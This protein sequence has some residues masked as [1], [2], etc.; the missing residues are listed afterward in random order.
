[1]CNNCPNHFS[2]FVN[3]GFEV[4]NNKRRG[5]SRTG[6][7]LFTGKKVFKAFSSIRSS[8][9]SIAQIVIDFPFWL[10]QVNAEKWVRA[11]GAS[12]RPQRQWRGNWLAGPC[13][14]R[15]LKDGEIY[16]QTFIGQLFSILVVCQ[17]FEQ[18]GAF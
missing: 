14:R 17:G 12:A 5:K 1:M 11:K 10:Q 9:I 2:I 15:S 7:T 3:F 16:Q 8:L 18:P 13:L 4:S 6:A